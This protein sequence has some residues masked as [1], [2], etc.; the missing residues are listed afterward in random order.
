MKGVVFNRKMKEIREDILRILSETD[1][2]LSAGELGTVLGV[3]REL[4]AEA[5]AE[6]ARE[7]RLALTRKGRAALPEQ[8]G[9]A[10]GRV[11]MS[12]RGF[13]FFI[14]EGQ[15]EDMFL[16]PQD[17]H[18]AMHGDMVW[19]RK[20]ENQAG[21]GDRAEVAMIAARRHRTVTGLFEGAGK[22]GGYV[23]PDDPRITID[24]IIPFRSMRGARDGDKV[25]AEI[26]QY[27]TGRRAM[28]GRIA[29]VLGPAGAVGM[30]MLSIIRRLELPDEFPDAAMAQAAALKPPTAAELTGRRNL[31]GLLTVTI[32]GAD[33]KDLD[34]AVSLEKKQD[35]GYT[36]WVHIA[37]VAHYVAAG[38]PI[39]R[40]A[41]RRGTSVYFPDRVL[42]M[43]PRELSNGLCSLNPGEDKLTL[44]CMMELNPKGKVTAYHIY[45]SVIRSDYRLTYDQ[46]NAIFAGDAA[47]RKKY[48]AA[49][50]MLEEMHILMAILRERRMRR[51]SIDFD[52]PEAGITLDGKGVAVDV[53]P[54]Q[55]GDAEKLIEEFMLCA[56]ET[57]AAHGI[58][59]SLPMPYRVHNQPDGARIKELN[60]FLGTLGHSLRAAGEEI[61]PID[62]QRLLNRVKG[63]PEETVVSRVTLRAMTKAKYAA[64]CTGH[65]GLAAGKYCHFT[66]PIRRYPDLLVHRAVK[67][68]MHR[69]MRGQY[70][71]ERRQSMPGMAQHC[72]E[73]ELAAVEAER[74]ADDLKKCEYMK[75]HIGEEYQGIISGV[76]QSGFFVELPNTVEGMVRSTSLTDDYYICD[77]KN[78]RMV[79][80]GS[81]R[82]FRLGDRVEIRVL[83]VDMEAARV[84]FGLCGQPEKRPARAGGD[85]RGK[86]G[87]RQGGQG[88][89]R[90]KAASQSTRA[91]KSDKISIHS[92]GKGGAKSGGKKRRPQARR[93]PKGTP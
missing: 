81:G 27:P 54:R 11:Q 57:V 64:E 44:S 75:A 25:V 31:K 43:L 71:E 56:N 50:P 66:S 16:S 23:I 46:V 34:D 45:E 47:L 68:S 1:R 40:E 41:Y 85:G 12:S 48:A 92:H 42:P 86:P 13:G 18:G 89:R 36:L 83:S 77:E 65:F 58:S 70:R 78:Y 61:K 26:T 7:G 51:G 67:D 28:A 3:G 5:M 21:G 39:D 63:A 10:Y 93:K 37:D 19:A 30:D 79:G 74:T 29:E 24:M 88:S 60:E 69:R 49:V 15:G 87:S 14:P 20:L 91:K 2:P 35:G 22:L 72:S 55:R 17:L 38:S 8:M 6:L 82:Q 32:D 73:R 52:L 53:Y 76:G 33:A 80:Q 90:K 59:R 84:E 62:V 4:A 9:L